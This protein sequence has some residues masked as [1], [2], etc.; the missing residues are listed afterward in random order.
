MFINVL[1]TNT[2]KRKWSISFGKL[3]RLAVVIGKFSPL[4]MWLRKPTNCQ[5]YVHTGVESIWKQLRSIKWWWQN[6]RGRTYHEYSMDKS[7]QLI[8]GSVDQPVDILCGCSI[9]EF[10]QRMYEWSVATN[11]V[12]EIFYQDFTLKLQECS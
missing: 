7:T 1:V 4:F 11:T 12:W 10:R 2:T 6:N 8:Q 9:I 3:T 5:G